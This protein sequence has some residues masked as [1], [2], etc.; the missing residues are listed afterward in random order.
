MST[1]KP[2]TLEEYE[3]FY[4][5]VYNVA[6]DMAAFSFA[7]NQLQERFPDAKHL[8][9]PVEETLLSYVRQLPEFLRKDVQN[10]LDDFQPLATRYIEDFRTA[11]L[12]KLGQ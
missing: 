11:V 3:E 9:E 6:G 2:E 4:E 1:K 12:A 8:L 10:N 5:Q 7:M